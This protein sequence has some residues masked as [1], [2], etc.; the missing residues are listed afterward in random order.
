MA[1][2]ADLD[3]REEHDTGPV[4]DEQHTRGE[5]LVDDPEADQA[6]DHS[7]PQAAMSH[8]QVPAPGPIR[9][10]HGQLCREPGILLAETG[11]DHVQLV[12]LV[13]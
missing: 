11:L 6:E 9:G 5:Y 4:K 7:Q 3:D 1:T 8:G 10:R 12:L 13:W 2:S